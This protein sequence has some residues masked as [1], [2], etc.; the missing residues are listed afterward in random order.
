MSV[1]GKLFNPIYQAVSAVLALY[2]SA[3]PNY[4][5]AIA[6]L[7]V[8]VMAVMI[9][10]TVTSTRSSVAMQR[11]NP[12]VSKLRAKYKSDKVKAQEEIMAL[13]KENN[14]SPAGGCLPMVLQLPIFIVLY[15]VVRGLTATVRTGHVV[16]P[17]PKYIS[18]TTLLYHHLVQ[19]GGKMIA[20]GLD[21]ARSATSVHGGFFRALPYYTLIAIA[22]ALQYLQM[23]Q[24]MSR[25]SQAPQSS[26]NQQTQQIQKYMPIAFGAIYITF[27]AAVT[28]YFVV[29][30]LFRIVQQ[31]LMY[32][33]DPALRV[34]TA[35]GSVKIATPPPNEKRGKGQTE[36]NR[37]GAARQVPQVRKGPRAPISREADKGTRGADPGGNK[38]TRK[39][40]EPRAR[41]NRTSGPRAPGR[42]GSGP[43][44]NG[45]GPSQRRARPPR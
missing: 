6:L 36:A 37:P 3:V 5:V 25:N 20:F 15:E 31:T 17:S 9:P 39:S 42:N 24:L 16:R 27:P 32:R 18:H 40:P 8:T 19:G 2:Y 43:S 7:T 28:V 45:S 30:S 41:S 29:S 44:T 26:I 12:E 11:L 10:L 13:Y 33:Y 21:L 14:V 35:A 1:L 4:A 34:A 23:R 38:A 22:V